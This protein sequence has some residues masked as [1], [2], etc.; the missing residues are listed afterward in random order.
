[1]KVARR[2]QVAV[3]PGFLALPRERA[4]KSAL[5]TAAWR[6]TL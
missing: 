1:M 4:E 6:A 2:R 3:P 5:F